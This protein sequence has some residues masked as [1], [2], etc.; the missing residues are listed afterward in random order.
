MAG[1]P[2][3]ELLVARL[4]HLAVKGAEVLPTLRA[5]PVQMRTDPGQ[6]K[7]TAQAVRLFFVAKV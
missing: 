6:Q 2:V 1:R 4:T 3:D 7:E 5:G